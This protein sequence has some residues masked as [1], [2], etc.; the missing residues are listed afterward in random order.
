MVKRLDTNDRGIKEAGFYVLRN[1]PCP[2]TLVELEFLSNPQ[3]E[4]DMMSKDHRAK[5]ADLLCDSIVKYARSK[6]Y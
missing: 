6:G 1:A 4:R 2:S 5:V 3:G